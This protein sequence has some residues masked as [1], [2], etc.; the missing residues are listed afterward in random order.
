MTDAIAEYD[1]T[2]DNREKR[3]DRVRQRDIDPLGEGIGCCGCEEG[4]SQDRTK[5]PGYDLETTLVG[6]LLEAE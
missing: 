4:D 5:D 3:N 1:P 2:Y 6:R